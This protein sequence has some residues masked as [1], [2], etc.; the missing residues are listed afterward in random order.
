[1]SPVAVGEDPHHKIF[2]DLNFG[3]K[4]NLDSPSEPNGKLLD[5]LYKWYRDHHALGYHLNRAIRI[6]LRSS[7]QL[8]W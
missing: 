8:G 1:M 4:L 6:H 3:N 5:N 2:E 7:L